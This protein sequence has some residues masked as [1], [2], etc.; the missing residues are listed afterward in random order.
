MFESPVIFVS[1]ANPDQVRVRQ[2]VDEL[3]ALGVVTWMDCKDLMPGSN[4]DLS[5]KK[6]QSRS[7]L[8]LLFISKNSINRRGY[9]QR[10]IKEALDAMKERIAEDIYIIPIRLDHDVQIPEEIKHLQ[11]VNY[12]GGET[13]KLLVKVINF[14]I[15]K[16][17][18]EIIQKQVDIGISWSERK[19]KESW[20]GAPGY[21][22]E[23][24][25]LEFSSEKYPRVVEATYIVRGAL[26]ARASSARECKTEKQNEYV[27]FGDSEFQR[28]S[29]WE[30]YCSDPMIVGKTMSLVYA[31]SWYGAGAAHP[32]SH[33]ETYAFTLDPFILVHS[34]ESMFVDPD[35][36]LVICSRKVR[37]LLL[38]EKRSREKDYNEN[39][40]GSLD[41]HAL[42]WINSGTE[43]WQNLNSFALIPDG[44]RIYFAPYQVGSYA[45]GS[46]EVVIP[47]E[48]IGPSLKPFYLRFC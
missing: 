15:E 3:E 31:V 2:I 33:W 27:N 21:Q 22:F 8:V 35:D 38:Q 12:E 28:L 1:Y 16:L 17:G 6:A 9:V 14:Q 7:D 42:K 29:T 46:Y 43:S 4:W 10:E 23:Y 30:A 25:W 44:I 19:Y 36:A 39:F 11:V 5:I 34:L 45:E 32:N 48:T 24:N 37:E 40:S 41:E 47:Y 13:A 26:A 20:D 18:K